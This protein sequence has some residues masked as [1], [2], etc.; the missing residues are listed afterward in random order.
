MW[1][2][3]ILKALKVSQFYINYFTPLLNSEHNNNKIT[4]TKNVIIY[5]VMQY[6]I[7]QGTNESLITI[8]S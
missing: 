8:K 3:I 7:V 1:K 2:E 5:G 4:D 6:S